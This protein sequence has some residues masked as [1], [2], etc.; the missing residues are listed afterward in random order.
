M[1]ASIL[2]P[3]EAGKFIAEHSVDVKIDPIGIEKTV[4]MVNILMY[5]VVMCISKIFC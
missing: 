3:R 2:M 4:D 1:S 5:L